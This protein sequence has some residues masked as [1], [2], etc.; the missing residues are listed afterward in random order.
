MQSSTG[1]AENELG[2]FQEIW[3]AWNDVDEEIRKKPIEHFRRAVD[4]QFDE[5]EEHLRN[6]D[7]TRAR[8]EAMD[9]ISIALNLLRRLD[10][11]PDDVEKI[12]RDRAVNRMH[13]QARS[14]LEKYET[15]YGI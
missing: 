1:P 7:Q 2:P 12:A 5:L 13:G 15:I 6:N 8:R 11:E 4:I 14:I 9:V 10:C 3:N